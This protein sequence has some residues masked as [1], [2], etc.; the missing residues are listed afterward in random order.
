MAVSTECSQPTPQLHPDSGQGDSQDFRKVVEAYKVLGK[1]ESR[2]S[3]DW[4][5]NAAERFGANHAN[6]GQYSYSNKNVVRPDEYYGVKGVKKVT[7]FKI[8]VLCAIFA[9]VGV[10]F[11]V[12][13]VKGSLAFRR[14]KLDEKSQEAGA[15]HAIA[16]ANATKYGNEAQLERL[17]A[18]L[19]KRG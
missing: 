13:L 3:Y 18:V 12:F 10:I 16:K 1:E 17:K 8:V 4:E 6:F 5:R 15:N 7:N 9:V 2:A 11:Q 14:R 19:E